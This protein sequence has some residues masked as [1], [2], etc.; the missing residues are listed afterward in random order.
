MFL[1]G[2]EK[3]VPKT[4]S[5]TAAVPGRAGASPPVS[6]RSVIQPVFEASVSTNGGGALQGRLEHVVVISRDHLPL[7]EASASGA[8]RVDGPGLEGGGGGGG[9]RLRHEH[10]RTS[11]RARRGG[12][13]Q[14]LMLLSRMV[15]CPC[16]VLDAS[17]WRVPG[18]EFS[19]V[20][21]KLQVTA[22]RELVCGCWQ[23]EDTHAIHMV[24]ITRTRLFHV[25]ILSPLVRCAIQTAYRRCG[26]VCEE[27]T[28]ESLVRVLTARAHAFGPT[29]FVVSRSSCSPGSGGK[30]PSSRW[31]LSCPR[32]SSPGGTL[33]LP[34]R[35]ALDCLAFDSW[36][37]VGSAGAC[38][39]V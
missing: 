23:D 2:R 14:Q 29:G 19:R 10:E 39:T 35:V 34:L 13:C 31:S 6:S 36:L 9:R 25:V 22:Q 18:E 24:I 11:S 15:A 8:C 26:C 12:C 7:A 21:P 3:L 33:A 38:L 5:T 28:N 20:F 32:C 37:V 17:Q 1:L 16:E 4:A 27:A 30:W